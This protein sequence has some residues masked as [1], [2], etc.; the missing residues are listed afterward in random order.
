MRII[1]NN[2][3]ESGLTENKEYLVTNIPNNEEVEFIDDDGRLR[4]LFN[5]E[6]KFKGDV[7]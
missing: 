7:Q 2:C 6:V 4:R 5:H 1:I 3:Q